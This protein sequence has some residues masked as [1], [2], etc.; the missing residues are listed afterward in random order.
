MTAFDVKKELTEYFLME[1]MEILQGPKQSVD[2]LKWAHY[3]SYISI[4]ISYFLAANAV[5]I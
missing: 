1:T 5:I 4:H 3:F 2:F